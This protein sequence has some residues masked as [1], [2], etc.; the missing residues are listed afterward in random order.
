MMKQISIWCR[1]LGLVC[2][3]LVGPVGESCVHVASP[4]SLW[5]W[6]HHW[7]WKI[8]C[9]LHNCI[10]NCIIENA[11]LSESTSYPAFLPIPLFCGPNLVF[12][13]PSAW[14]SCT[15]WFDRRPFR[16]VCHCLLRVCSNDWAGV[17]GL[18]VQTQHAASTG[19]YQCILAKVGH[20]GF[21]F[22]HIWWTTMCLMSSSNQRRK[23]KEL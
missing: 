3:S 16:Y 9:D 5:P 7:L 8:E 13:V 11:S 19:R 1:T 14:R 2:R 15:C 17:E 6:Q 4:P 10:Q 12:P 18:A 21:R 23:L 20:V 22:Y